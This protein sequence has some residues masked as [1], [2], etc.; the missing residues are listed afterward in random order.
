MIPILGQQI[1]LPKNQGMAR[2]TEQCGQVINVKSE[3]FQFNLLFHGLEVAFSHTHTYEFRYLIYIVTMQHILHI[4]LLSW[5]LA[6]SDYRM[7]FHHYFEIK[8]YQSIEKMS[9]QVGHNNN[10][11]FQ[12]CLISFGPKC[13]C[14]GLHVLLSPC[15]WWAYLA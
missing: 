4:S 1:I 15:T 12:T 7:L 11:M 6:K 10:T 14:A 8:F 5:T 9:S 13:R 2:I 3:C